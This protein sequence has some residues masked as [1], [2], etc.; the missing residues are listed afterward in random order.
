MPAWLW[1]LRAG[2]GRQ[3]G[4]PLGLCAHVSEEGQA[5][6]ARHVL[7]EL[8]VEDLGAGAAVRACRR[9]LLRCVLLRRE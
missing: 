3:G 4:R 5:A 7:A 8:E 1:D 2:V 9:H 6:A